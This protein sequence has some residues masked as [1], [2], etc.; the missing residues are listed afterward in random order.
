MAVTAQCLR[1]LTRWLAVNFVQIFGDRQYVLTATGRK[2]SMAMVM[3]TERAI[4]RI[5]KQV[6]NGIF[7]DVLLSVSKL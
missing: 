1:C 7:K 2:K 6:M 5:N 3:A 4:R